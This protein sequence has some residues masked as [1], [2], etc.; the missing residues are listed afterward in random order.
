MIIIFFL[1]MNLFSPL[2]AEE[3]Y[4]PDLTPSE[5]NTWF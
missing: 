2:S 5:E 1:L 3:P 4:E